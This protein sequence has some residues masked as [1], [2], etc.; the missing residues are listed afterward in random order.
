MTELKLS[1]CFKLARNA[2]DINHL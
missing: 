1:F 2:S